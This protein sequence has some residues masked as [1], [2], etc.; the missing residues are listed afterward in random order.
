[1]AKNHG[2]IDEYRKTSAIL[3]ALR[4]AQENHDDFRR[5]PHFMDCKPLSLRELDA[6]CE[7]V[8]AGGPP[9]RMKRG[10]AR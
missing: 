7:E 9:Q 1:M 5:M 8:N 4:L 6:V 10:K 3:A 2:K